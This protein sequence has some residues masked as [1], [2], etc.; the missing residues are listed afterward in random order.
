MGRPFDRDWYDTVVSACCLVTDFEQ[1]QN[2][3]STIVGDRGVQLS[4][5]QRARIGL[6]RA[7]YRDSDVLILDDPL[8]AVDSRVGRM[9]FYNAILGLA[10]NR[11]RRR[12]GQLSSA[13]TVI[14][15][16][17]QHQF[18]HDQKCVLM[19]DGKIECIGAYNDCVDASRGKLRKSL[20]NVG[21]DDASLELSS[22]NNEVEEKINTTNA[23][24][25]NGAACA[26]H[27]EIKV[28][29]V[30]QRQTFLKYAN[31]MGG[32]MVGVFFIIL[33]SAAQASVLGTIAAIGI[34]SEKP[35]GEQKEQNI[36]LIIIGLGL[37]TIVLSIVRAFGSFHLLV[38][39]SR[40]LHDKM[41]AS[42]L[43]AKIQFFDTN[44]LG[45]ILNM[46]SADVG[47]ND[48]MLPT[49]MFDC[50]MCAFL[51]LG[52]IVTTL[53]VLPYT[54]LALPPLVFYFIWVRRIYVTTTRELKRL[55]GLARSPIYAMLSEAL[56]GIATIRANDA[57]GHF[58]KLF[59][60]VH[61]NHCR[62]FFAF[63]SASRWVGFRMD[64]IMFLFISVA[65][66]LAVLFNT[67][68]W[69]SVDP[70]IL[71]LALSMLLQLSG[72]FQWAVRQSAE[73]VN[74][75]VSVER[76][77]EFGNLEPEATLRKPDTDPPN[78]PKE[79][80]IVIKDLSV[81][82]R[83]LLPL[84]LKKVSLSIS[85]GERVGVVGRTGR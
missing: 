13:V 34:W 26:D 80:S 22:Q 64:S 57:L 47:S 63:I 31:A 52:S 12:R 85:A 10:L 84:A 28:Q 11:N 72:I 2:R 39:A 66:F 25:S 82:Y 38:K 17:H 49:T 71:G 62:A 53:S 45:R 60:N 24:K 68:A 43:R 55:E 58:R 54:F 20:Y 73:V 3:D 16:T 83:S 21:E 50:L 4:G 65:A 70:A 59:E 78:W 37:A 19:L 5:G 41:T 7:L 18:L 15:A 9:I 14:L 81:R 75:M 61:N 23:T 30:V 36:I 67:Q 74:L 27:D 56:V 44:P 79:G 40:K 33:F 76:V 42:V 1:L 8:S 48:D 32:I 35:E 69:F 29:G 6:A 77:S 51:C 46:F